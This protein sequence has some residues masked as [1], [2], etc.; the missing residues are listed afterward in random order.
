M[1]PVWA[2]EV[3]VLGEP[4]ESRNKNHLHEA[5]AFSAAPVDNSSYLNLLSL[6][7]KQDVPESRSDEFVSLFGCSVM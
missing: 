7:A 6:R 3:L 4:Y 5:L 1:L 2:L